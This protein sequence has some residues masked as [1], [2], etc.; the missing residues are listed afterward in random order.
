MLNMRTFI[1]CV[2]SFLPASP[3]LSKNV[4]EPEACKCADVQITVADCSQ[5]AAV[6]KI[7]V[8]TGITREGMI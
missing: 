3:S 1:R 2:N 7:V 4:S 8:S 5:D 6:Y